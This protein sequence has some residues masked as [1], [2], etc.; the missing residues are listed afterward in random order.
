M[1]DTDYIFILFLILISIF[2]LSY[3]PST[4]DVIRI[5]VGSMISKYSNWK[6]NKLKLEIHNER[7]DKEQ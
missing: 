3:T 5:K 1:I 4:L 6:T 7:E 2:S